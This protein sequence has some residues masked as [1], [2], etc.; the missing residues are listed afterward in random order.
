M[1]NERLPGPGSAARHTCRSEQACAAV[2]TAHA[3]LYAIN[4]SDYS[5][6]AA[7]ITGP[8]ATV[9]TTGSARSASGSA[10]FD[11]AGAWEAQTCRACPTGTQGPAGTSVYSTDASAAASCH[12][13]A[14]DARPTSAIHQGPPV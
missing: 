14:S 13:Q 11:Y 1:W 6:H 12:A 5:G 7:D 2:A 4:T 9:H 10:A 8:G 3:S